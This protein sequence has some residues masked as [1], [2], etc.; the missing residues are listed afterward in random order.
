MKDYRIKCP[1]CNRDFYG[2][3]FNDATHMIQAHIK[4]SCKKEIQDYK[5]KLGYVP[6]TKEDPDSG[7][8]V[9]EKREV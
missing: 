8:N 3:D 6:F 1:L 9:S 2:E 4:Y 7:G 5:E